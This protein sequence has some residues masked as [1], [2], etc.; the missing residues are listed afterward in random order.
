[1]YDILRKILTKTNVELI[2]ENIVIETDN[3]DYEIF[4]DYVIT[5]SGNKY[6]VS[7]HKTHLEMYFYTLKNA[8]IWITLYK[9]NKIADAKRVGDLDSA[10][11]GANFS[12]ELN[13]KLNKRATDLNLKS[14]YV[15]KIVES[16]AKRT[17]IRKELESFEQQVKAW[18][19]QKF[20]QL[21]S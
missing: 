17:S 15:A 18:Q 8:V 20:N 6:K 11:E 7:S 12:I 3:G 16:K 14:I 13:D 21:V 9:L 5:S 2:S 19:Y 10:L 1:M 4:G